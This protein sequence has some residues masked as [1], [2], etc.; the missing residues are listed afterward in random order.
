MEEIFGPEGLIAR[1]H[2]EYEYRPGQIQMAEAVLRAFEEKRHLIVEAGTGTGKTLAYLVPAVA[3]ATARKTRVVIS[4][5]TKNLQEQLMEKDIPFLQRV[6]PRKFTAAYMKGRGNY[7]CLQR[8]KR[9]ENSPVLEG[10]DE[11]DYFDEVRRW[12][13]ES[14]TGDRAE[15]VGL[16]E[17][18]SFWRHLDA[19]TE[20]CLGQKCPD[21]DPC[22]ITRMR[23][24]ATDADI[25]IVNHHLFFADLALRNGEYGQVL[26][27]YSAVIFDEAHQ[28]EDVAAEYFGAQVSS[29]QMEDLVRD[30]AQLPLTNVEANRE[31]TRTAARLTRFSDNFWMGFREGRGEEGR[32]PILPGTFARKRTDGQIEAT[33]LGEAYLSLDGALNRLETT[34]DALPEQ[35]LEVENILR[36]IRQIRFDLQFI[37][38]GDD[39]AFVYW[40]E[41]RGRGAF[42]RASPIDVSGLLQEK[43]F[44]RVETVVLTS[45]T[46]ASAGNFNFIRERLGLTEAEDLV[47]PSGYDYESQAVLYLPQRLPD[48]RSPQFADA[49]AEEVIRLLNATEGRAFVLSTSFAGMKALY[50]RVAGEVDF[51]CFLQGTASKAG[52]LEKFRETPHAVLFA[53]ASFW[54]GV[55]V[56][57]EQLSCVI[58]DKLPFAVPSDPV[59]A[60][61][62]RYIDDQGGSSFYE[63]SVPQAI[64]SLKQG[65]GRLIRSA[66][67][68]GVLAVLD[69]RLRTKAY[70]RLFLESLP[71]CRVTSN[72]A[73]LAAIFDKRI[74]ETQSYV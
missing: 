34:L 66:T 25:V 41:R 57:G 65:L 42:L 48:P 61:R 7:A 28:I 26:P 5:G 29:Y 56:R 50:E 63:Y 13:R 4:T 24:R 43:L 16:P 14:G 51:P 38:A 18:L 15:L 40:L 35:P 19:R 3:A 68:R 27:D 70:G 6:L 21:Y 69:P 31:L 46:L 55:D 45:A 44:E 64:I 20:I 22:F 9:A 39:R 32:A 60:A 23:Q 62:Q 11:L 74:P 30:L 1:A 37:V 71:P 17:N 67:D 12:A 49:A 54:Q 8:I 59:V 73:D 58:I 10:L 72:I 36:R 2:L 52:L 33:P 47:A 53:T